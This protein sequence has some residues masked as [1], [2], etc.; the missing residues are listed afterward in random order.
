MTVC[1][2]HLRGIDGP[3]RWLFEPTAF[4]FYSDADCF[5]GGFIPR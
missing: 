1:V 2:A 5:Q 4:E 3:G